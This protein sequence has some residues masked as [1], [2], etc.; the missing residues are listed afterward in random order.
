MNASLLL[1]LLKEAAREQGESVLAGDARIAPDRFG[2]GGAWSK[3]RAK[4]LRGNQGA[5]SRMAVRGSRSALSP[6]SDATGF[7]PCSHSDEFCHFPRK[8]KPPPVL[9][10]WKRRVRMM[11]RGSSHTR[12]KGKSHGHTE[13]QYNNPPAPGLSPPLFWLVCHHLRVV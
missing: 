10:V 9:P 6:G 2:R 7:S 5:L 13:R 8:G 11:K 4:L 3:A 12:R 1:K